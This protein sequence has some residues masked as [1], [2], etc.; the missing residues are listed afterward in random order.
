MHL[1]IPQETSIVKTF[2][3]TLITFLSSKCHNT[4]PNELYGRRHML[5]YVGAPLQP[6]L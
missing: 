3:V 6:Y 5:Q 1:I 2:F 4:S